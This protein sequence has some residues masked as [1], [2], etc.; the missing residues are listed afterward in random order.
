MKNGQIW[1]DVDGN[2]IQAHGGCIIKFGNLYYWYGEHK[3]GPNVP[4][5]KVER[6]DV[7]GVS[8]YTSRDLVNWKYEGLALEA[9]K[10]DP[11]SPLHPSKV[12]ERPK[13]LY[14]EKTGK[15]VMWFHSDRA[16][17]QFARAGV[18]I[19]D[20]PKGPFVFL[21]DFTPNKQDSRDMTVYKDKD[22]VAY[23]FHSANRNK[24]MNVARLTED[25][26]NVD[27]LFV[28]VLPDQER[29]APALF[30]YDGMYYMISSGCTSWNPNAA[31]YAEC[32]HLMGKWKLI[33]NPLEGKDA[34]I[35]FYGQS[36]YIF[37]AEG[38]FYLMLDHWK[39]DSL[40]YSGYSILPIKVNPDKT[41]T[42]PWQD[43]WLG[44]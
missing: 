27:G 3:G 30:F 29:E 12:L 44:I 24:T 33:D 38:A 39:P 1:Y 6:V 26:T 40:R 32:P 21:R 19:S 34:R 11:E 31:L 18:A 22:G 13:V 41:L 5:S 8:C 2:D 14:N 42:V 35:T 23:L 36:A 9:D 43:E 4:N 15:Y 37:E 17:Y 25:Y 10:S 7:I 16:D 28:S 20:N